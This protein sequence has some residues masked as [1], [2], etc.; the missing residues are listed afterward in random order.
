MENEELILNKLDLL[1]QGIDFIKEHIADL[2]LTQDDFNSL[3]EAEKDLME[4][5]T[6]RL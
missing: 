2:T 6:K 1:K 4:G 3:Y 5:K